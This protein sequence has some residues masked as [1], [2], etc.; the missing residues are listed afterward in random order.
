MEAKVDIGPYQCEIDVINLNHWLQQLEIYFSV[1]HI[2]EDHKIYFARPKLEGHALTWWES[3]TKT[4]R[5]EGD[6]LVNKW[7]D[8][9]TLIK[10]Q[11][12]LIGYV[13]D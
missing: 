5:L 11:F 13:E 7:E 2:E 8:F 12:H 4:L 3:H 6:L 9:K 10:S 1:H